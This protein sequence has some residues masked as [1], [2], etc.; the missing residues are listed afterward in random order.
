MASIGKIVR[1][2]AAPT[3]MPPPPD[4]P[5]LTREDTMIDDGE[6]PPA[7]K[8]LERAE[9]MAGAAMSE[10]EMP[11]PVAIKKKSSNHAWLAFLKQY[12]KDNESSTAGM[13]APQIASLASKE[14]RKQLPPPCPACG[15]R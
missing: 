9:T 14:Y 11:P 1:P 7:P 12:R 13:S 6:M 3:K 8:P 4:P 10:D 15:K 5:V 2:S